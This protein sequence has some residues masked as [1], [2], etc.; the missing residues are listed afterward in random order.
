M[1]IAVVVIAYHFWYTHG[2][3]FNFVRNL[4]VVFKLRQMRTTAVRSRLRS[5]WLGR[6]L[7]LRVG[8]LKNDICK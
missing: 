8:G 6:M 4:P 2:E 3:I 7:P 5:S 1:R